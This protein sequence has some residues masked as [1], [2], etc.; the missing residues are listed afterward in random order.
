[1]Q[2]LSSKHVSG[3][4]TRLLTVFPLLLPVVSSADTT[5]TTMAVSATVLKACLTAAA[6]LAFGDYTATSV[7]A[8]D[9]IAEIIVTC[10]VGTSYEVALDAGT[11]TGATTTIRK[12][13]YL[14][15]TLNY[16]LFKDS[17]RS[18]NWGNTV[19]TDTVTG[20]GE[21]LHTVYGHIP[22]AQYGAPGAYADT[23]TVTVTY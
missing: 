16:Q 5:T 3:L 2:T 8:N 10:T 13:S 12:M 21:G 17:S 7:S 20:T 19:G 4:I 22:P 1:M 11:G 14:S 9:A 6:P 15:N 18:Q 23:I